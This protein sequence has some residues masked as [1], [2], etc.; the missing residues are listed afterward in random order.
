V[1]LDNADTVIEGGPD[2]WLFLFK[3]FIERSYR[4][5]D[6]LP[7]SKDAGCPRFGFVNLGLGVRSFPSPPYPFQI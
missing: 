5:F 1:S 2:Y 6:L 7:S 3:Q 4:L